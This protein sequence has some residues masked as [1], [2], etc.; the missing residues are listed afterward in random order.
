MNVL[1]LM[2]KVFLQ[3]TGPGQGKFWSFTASIVIDLREEFVPEKHPTPTPMTLSPSI[4]VTVPCNTRN[5][6]MY[7]TPRAKDG[8]FAQPNLIQYVWGWGHPNCS[9]P[10]VAAGSSGQFIYNQGKYKL[11]V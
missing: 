8:I 4:T 6:N 2:P 3:W 5:K 7:G 9:P 11:H 10:F 1:Y